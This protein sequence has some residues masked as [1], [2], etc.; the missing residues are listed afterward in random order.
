M[1][2]RSSKPEKSPAKRA[3]LSRRRRRFIWRSTISP[4]PFAPMRLSHRARLTATWRPSPRSKPTK[5]HSPAHAFPL[6]NHGLNSND[7]QEERSYEQ[8]AERNRIDPA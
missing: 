5:R 8:E 1:L 2:Q 7:I 3:R 6:T 4:A